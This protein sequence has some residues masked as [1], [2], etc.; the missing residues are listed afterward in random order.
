MNYIPLYPAP[1]S[2]PN[3]QRKVDELLVPIFLHRSTYTCL[4]MKY[5]KKVKILGKRTHMQK[6]FDIVKG[7][8]NISLSLEV[9]HPKQIKLKYRTRRTTLS[10]SRRNNTQKKTVSV[11]LSKVFFPLHIKTAYALILP[12]LHVCCGG[13]KWG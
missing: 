2:N 4:K 11:D 1:N 9:V 3:F 13:E 5:S 7:I 10:E 6:L 8:Q 12:C